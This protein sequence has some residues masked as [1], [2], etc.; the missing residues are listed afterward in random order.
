MNVEEGT[1]MSIKERLRVGADIGR[2]IMVLHTYGWS[3]KEFFCSWF[4]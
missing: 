3:F 2:V 1:N 4:N